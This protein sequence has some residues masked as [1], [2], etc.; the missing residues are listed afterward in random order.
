MANS[1]YS[2]SA[3]AATRDALLVV[4]GLTVLA[5]CLGI[6]T[7]NRGPSE[8]F[9]TDNMLNATGIDVLEATCEVGT[10]VPGNSYRLA[11]IDALKRHP[12]VVNACYFATRGD[13]SLMDPQMRMCR[14]S[15]DVDNDKVVSSLGVE[16]VLGTTQ[17]VINLVP[18]LDPS[19]YS[20]YEDQL[21]NIAVERSNIYKATF[22]SFKEAQ[23]MLARLKDQQQKAMTMLQQQTDLYNA[24][25][26]RLQLVNAALPNVKASTAVRSKQVD[27]L[28]SIITS[29]SSAVMSLE[30]D[31]AKNKGA[32][33]A[34]AAEVLSLQDQLKQL[35]SS[36]ATLQQTIAD[37]D[38]QISRLASDLSAVNAVISRDTAAA[39]NTVSIYNTQ[40]SQCNSQ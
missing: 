16:Q 30:A 26:A 3:S 20:G 21:A 12:N 13:E 14:R 6:C 1:S 4:A 9:L 8:R 15:A 34:N 28:R 29:E 39:N 37:R 33:A 40:A 11:R 18:N 10:R 5:I 23:T 32:Y 7:C 38:T 22:G 2:S 35:A 27:G 36:I 25:V 24:T 17:C 31:I 19:L